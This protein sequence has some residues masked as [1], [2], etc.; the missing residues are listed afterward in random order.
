MDKKIADP[1]WKATLITKDAI[2]EENRVKT[3]HLL[4]ND[5]LHCANIDKKLLNL[6]TF[7]PFLDT[8]E[9][10]HIMII[11]DDKYEAD[12]LAARYCSK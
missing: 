6:N 8:F 5:R 11:F 12:E 3:G 2:L 7:T 10:Q 1:K 4:T 9:Y